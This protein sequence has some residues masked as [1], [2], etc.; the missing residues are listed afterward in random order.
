MRST[1][2]LGSVGLLALRASLAVAGPAATRGGVFI[3]CSFHMLDPAGVYR[4]V[5][6]YSGGPV[7]CSLPVGSGTYSGK[8]VDRVPKWPMGDEVGSSKLSLRGG[9]ARGS[10]RISGN[11]AIYTYSGNMKF[12]DGTGRFRHVS[13]T[14]ALKCRKRL[15]DMVCTG[16]GTVRGI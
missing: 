14:L 12:L 2:K 6:R 7:K 15:P 4:P 9:T 1:W 5:G 3:R 10:Y 16:S 8:Y 13:G 11:A